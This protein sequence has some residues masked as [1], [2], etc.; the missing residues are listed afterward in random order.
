MGEKQVTE[1]ALSPLLQVCNCSIHFGGLAAVNNLT[2]SLKARELMAIIGPNGAG[3]TTLFNMLTGVYTPSH[4]DILFLNKSVVGQRA[5][6]I[7][8]RGIARTFQNIRIFENLSVAD[9]VRAA[10]YSRIT[11]NLFSASLG[12][13]KVRREEETI[14]QETNAFLKLFHL[15]DRRKERS[16]NLSYGEQRRLEIIRALVTR[17]KLLLLDEPAA[18]MNP[19]EKKEL[20]SLIRR[21]HL[22]YSM[23]VILIEHDMQVVMNIAPRILV[24]DY[25]VPIAEGAPN[26]IRK[27]PKVIE[28]YLGEAV[29]GDWE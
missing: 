12:L 18:G 5:D 1:Q 4:G 28:A 6:Q 19:V 3:K 8:H 2:F 17:P 27:N 13:S 14:D 10:Y 26:E 9:N 21:I 25:G 22:E 24:L 15:F 16:G 23:A 20:V 29:I 11:T 7:N